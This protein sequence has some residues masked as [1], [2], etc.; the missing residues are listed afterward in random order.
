MILLQSGD[1]VITKEKRI[2]EASGPEALLQQ[3]LIRLKAHK[4]SF[5]LDRELGSELFK[6]DVER[7]SAE[8]IEPLIREAI[9]P[10]RGLRL[11]KVRREGEED[12]LGLT[13]YFEATGETAQVSVSV[14]N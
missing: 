7:S 9:A 14:V 2:L 1:N 12:R 6:L 10:V 8:E 13:L 11:L 3:A 5:P 4:G